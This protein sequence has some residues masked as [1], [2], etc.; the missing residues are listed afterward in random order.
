MYNEQIKLKVPP[1]VVVILTAVVCDQTFPP[2][3]D[4]HFRPS[5]PLQKQL[6]PELIV[7]GGRNE[8]EKWLGAALVALTGNH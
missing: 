4:S 5:P 6:I 7:F 3:K 1:K 2:L 8:W